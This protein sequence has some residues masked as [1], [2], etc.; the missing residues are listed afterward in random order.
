MVSKKMTVTLIRLITICALAFVAPAALA[1][2][3]GVTFDG[4]SAD[5]SAASGI[6]VS[7]GGNFTIYVRFDQVVT[8]SPASAAAPGE[9]FTAGDLTLT[10]FS[11]IGGVV[12]APSATIGSLG[13]GRNFTITIYISTLSPIAELSILLPR[14][15]VGAV[16]PSIGDAD[17]ANEMENI[18]VSVL[19]K[20]PVLPPTVYEIRQI[21][22]SVPI[23]TTAE[24]R[25]RILLSEAPK[26]GFTRNLI[27]V[28]GA[29]VK[30]VLALAPESP[31]SSRPATWRDKMLHACAVT[32][33]TR[34]GQNTVA[35]R[36]RSFQGLGGQTY[37]PPRFPTEGKH[38]LTIQTQRAALARTA[39]LVVEI[40]AG[41]RILDYLVI[42]TNIARSGIQKPDDSDANP[43]LAHKRTPAQMKYNVIEGA[44]P[45]LE[46]F[47][48]AGGR[49]DLVSS[50]T[51]T[52]SEIMWGADS[53]LTVPQSS[54]W[55]EIKNHSGRSIVTGPNTHRLIFYGANETPPAS[56]AGIADRVGTLN[57]VGTYWSITGKGTSGAQGI[58]MYRAGGLDG[59]TSAAWRQSTRPALNFDPNRS[60]NRIG[61]P[62][63]DTLGAP[64][65]PPPV[66]TPATTPKT[67]PATTTPTPPVTPPVTVVEPDSL[68]IV[69]SA[70]R[71]A[72][73]VNKK[74][75]SPLRVRVIDLDEDGVP[76]TRVIFRVTAGKGKLG[77][78]GPGRAV[79]VETDTGGYARVDFTPTANGTATVQANTTGLD[80]TVKFTIR[81]GATT[82]DSPTTTS[83][84]TPKTTQATTPGTG[85]PPRTT[86]NPVVHVGASKRLPMVWVDGGKIYGLIGADVKEFI[87]GVENAMSVTVGGGKVYWT[88]KTSDTHGTLNSANLDGTGAKE[89]RKDPLWGVPRGIAV[90][91]AGNKLYWVDA[92]GRL[93]RAALDGS[94][95]QNVLRNLPDPVDIA[96]AD[97]KAYWTQGNGSVWFVNLTGTKTVR[98]ISRGAKAA[99]SLV[100]VGEKV[101]WTEKTGE[102]TGTLNSANL[103]GTAAKQLLSVPAVPMGIAVDTQRSSLYWTDA[104]GRIQSANLDGSL[105][106]KVVSGLVR[107]GDMV[108]SSSLTETSV[109]TTP[110]GATPAKKAAPFNAQYD[111][112]GDGA[113]NDTDA[114]LVTRAISNGSTDAKYDVN[115]DG[116][117]NFDDLQLILENRAQ[118]PY[119]I[120][121]DG[122]VDDA[123]ASLVTQAISDGST[124]AQY[125]V[126]GDGEVN[127]D[128][129]QLVLQNRAPEA[130]GAPH[131]VGNPKWTAAQMARL[132]AQIHLLIATGDRSPAAMRTLIY[133]QQLLALARPEKTQ[134]LANYPN[135]FNPETW[136]PYELAT[137]TTVKIT[138]YNAQGVVIRTLQLGQQSAGYYTDRERA[139]Y[140]D[141]R[142]A[143]G[144]QVASGIYFYQLETDDMSSLRKMVILK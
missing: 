77:D 138:I 116:Q 14:G 70:T 8:T 22:L 115:G 132:Q 81:T 102:S 67:T 63:A 125:D 135:P 126:N 31:T 2:D 62:G 99:G 10:A 106:Q 29:D 46:S 109:V 73:T 25:V 4:S 118:S 113:V 51:L 18:R 122:T 79:A 88:E 91:A 9:A 19:S 40:P 20:N 37:N 49:I 76:N 128:D 101:Y 84:T 121:G 141:G 68:K 16:D 96:L 33:A 89:L 66:A 55:I 86:V 98:N 123:D 7:R 72:T 80:Q 136:I 142:N 11:S 92:V 36:V 23:I 117:V 34:P 144:E 94:G 30:S 53:R 58:S 139:A 75:D 127:F 137:D 38:I 133:L 26:G 56:R 6:Q 134:L 120:D 107:P 41:K 12:A 130:A 1:G 13:D 83:Q 64:A 78:R 85:T 27:D 124:D 104:T 82:P 21:G 129:L 95:I 71:T 44:L 74:I 112:N 114:S 87:A 65:Q 108:L 39:G 48:R 97:G 119:D 43:P 90:D 100:I 3:F 59:T 105:I 17:D 140:W 50:D 131:I 28:T 45:N 5:V 61:S 32:L 103:D 93:Q 42:A 35:I 69:G 54:Q 57:A 15:R 24:F 110:P 52:I 111:V 60:G 143:L 47:L